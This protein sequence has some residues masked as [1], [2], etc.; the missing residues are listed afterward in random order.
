MTR[1]LTAR[2]ALWKARGLFGD[3]ATASVSKCC[4]ASVYGGKY[5]HMSCRGVH[6][7]PCP[8]GRPVYRI[9][10]IVLCFNSIQGEG[11]TWEEALAKASERKTRGM[12]I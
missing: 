10:K 1:K 9:G 4:V 2:T 7:Q 3:K 5:E 11:G 6:E 12:D 8:G